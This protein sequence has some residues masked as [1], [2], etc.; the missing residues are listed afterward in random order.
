MTLFKDFAFKGE[1]DQSLYAIRRDLAGG[2]NNRMSGTMIAENEGEQMQ[3]VDLGIPGKRQRM[4]GSVLIGNDI[5]NAD[6]LAL[7]NF[8]INGQT[9]QLLLA[10][11]T[12]L[13][14]WEGSGNWASVKADFSAMTECSLT[15]GKE[16]GLAP[17][18]I[19]LVANDAG[20]NVFRID[21]GGAEQDLGDT[22]TSPLKTTV[23]AWY[24]NRF[25]GLKDSLLAF[26]DAYAADYSAAFD[27]TTNVYRVPVGEE[28]ALLPTRDLGLVCVGAEEIWAIA[29]S[30][31]P[32]A[33]DQPEPLLTGMGCVSKN[34]AVV[35]GDDIYFFAPDGLRAL[36]RTIQDKLQVGASYPLS[37]NLKTEFGNIVWARIS[38]LS[39][40]YFDNK[41]F[42]SV[43]VAAGFATWV[44]FLATNSFATYEGIHPR[45]WSKYKVGGEQR[46]YYGK[47]G[48]GTVYQGWQGTTFEG[49]T[50]S[51]GTAIEYEEIGREEDLG[52]PLVYKSGG[53]LEVRVRASGAYTIN[54]SAQFDN[55]GWNLL[56]TINTAGNLVTFPIAFPVTF[57]D[58]NVVS[59]KFHI[60]GYGRWRTCQVK[61][62]NNET[63][64]SEIIILEHSII[65]F[66]EEYQNE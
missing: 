45:C 34:G 37:Y 52:Q 24:R 63:G 31:T 47:D 3:N 38:E 15:F 16:S 61:L 33:T 10:E 60:D 6:P 50:D 20:D 66:A 54:V 25:W 56:G 36:K 59:E 64:S 2:I 48:D 39:L 32:V 11:N 30:A 19:V 12:T 43:P 27:R 18:D 65:S 29:P 49:T 17:D 44:Y 13:W 40:E 26:S 46:V 35:A 58:P 8:V 41:I 57:T 42:C 9:D 23:N 21:S 22:N 14:K 51:N 62:Y 55:S 53:E 28:R 4:P 7:G 5:G 1:D